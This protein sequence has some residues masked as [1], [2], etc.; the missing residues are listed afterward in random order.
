MENT[1]RQIHI[2]AD[3]WHIPV[4]HSITEAYYLNVLIP[5]GIDRFLARQ[6]ELRR[7]QM[8]R[9]PNTLAA[10][11]TLAVFGA[12]TIWL[13]SRRG[14]AFPSVRTTDRRN[15]KLPRTTIDAIRAFSQ[16]R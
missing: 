2:D 13:G 11:S 16:G 14:S 1:N 3:P 8:E 15:L 7:Q 6:E 4:G 5:V 9:A 12:L 10:I